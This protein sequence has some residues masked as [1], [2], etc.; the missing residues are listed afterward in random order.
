[1]DKTVFILSSFLYAVKLAFEEQSMKPHAQEV[2]QHD[3]V[4]F[5]SLGK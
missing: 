1:M 5:L 2:L 3:K 4:V